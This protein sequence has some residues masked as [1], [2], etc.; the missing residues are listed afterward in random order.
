MSSTPYSFS[1]YSFSFLPKS[2]RRRW[3]MLLRAWMPV[4]FVLGVL[5]VESSALL[6]ADRTSPPLHTLAHAVSGAQLD[7]HWTLV[8]RLVRKTGHF[9]GYGIFSLAL[10]RAWMLSLQMDRSWLHPERR[11]Q[12][13]AIAGT[14]AVAA[15]DELHQAFVPNRTG[16]FADVLLDIAG[17]VALQLVV[18]LLGDAICWMQWDVHLASARRTAGERVVA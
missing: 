16:K 4:L 7:S 8:H 13:M 12:L 1:P 5:G 10:L 11:M 15:L 14:F 18:R 2:A 17:A 9:V 3:L 6:A